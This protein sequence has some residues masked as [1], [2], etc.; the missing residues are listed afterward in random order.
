MKGSVLGFDRDRDKGLI[1]GADGEQYEFR[2]AEWIADNGIRT[3]M[4]VEFMPVA[5]EARQ[6]SS[7]REP[8]SS[9]GQEAAPIKRSPLAIITLICGILSLGGGL[10]FQIVAIVCGH[11]ARSEI[12]KSNGTL[13]GDG[14]AITGLIMGYIGVSVALVTVVVVVVTMMFGT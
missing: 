7:A 1:Q 12:R 2:Q 14:M 11:M 9:L 5:G 13:R 10:V 3:N 4:E 6:I 8:V